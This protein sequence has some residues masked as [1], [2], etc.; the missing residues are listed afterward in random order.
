MRHK[1]NYSLSHDNRDQ[2]PYKFRAYALRFCEKAQINETNFLRKGKL[3]KQKYISGINTRDFVRAI[4]IQMINY[5]GIRKC[6]SALIQ[7]DRINVWESTETRNIKVLA[8]R[9]GKIKIYKDAIEKVYP[10]EEE[11]EQISKILDELE[12][13]EHLTTE[14]NNKIREL[15]SRKEI[16]ETTIGDKMN[17]KTDDQLLTAVR[18]WMDAIK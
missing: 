13:T 15:K 5:H 7:A 3:I 16:I 1:N 11:L 14:Q 18:K 17:D 12:N 10:L 4:T 6:V 2:V 9:I 8:K